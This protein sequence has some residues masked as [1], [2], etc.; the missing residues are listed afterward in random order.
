[1]VT[2]TETKPV[3]DGSSLEDA[4]PTVEI[5]MADDVDRM[6]Y[7]CPLGH[8]NWD[9][10]NNHIWCQSCSRQAAHDDDISPEYYEVLDQATGESIPWSAIRIAGEDYNDE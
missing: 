7:T 1:M 6:R 8:R 2:T 9:R 4:H 10:T 3:T 5:D